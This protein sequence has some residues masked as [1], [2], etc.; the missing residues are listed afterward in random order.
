M[1]ASSLDMFADDTLLY[2]II[3]SLADFVKLQQDL[4]SLEIW[5]ARD[6]MPFNASR[7]DKLTITIKKLPVMAVYRLSDKEIP[8]PVLIKSLGVRL[9]SGLIF[10]GQS[11]H[12]GSQ[13]RK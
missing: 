2:R 4:D 5:L 13:M 3:E 1:L 8:S 11:E 10:A 6:Q 9:N 7:S 12:V